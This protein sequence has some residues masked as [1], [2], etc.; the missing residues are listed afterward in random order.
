MTGTSV[1]KRASL[2]AVLLIF[3]CAGSFS[4]SSRNTGAVQ[5]DRAAESKG[6]YY[7]AVR[8]GL[9]TEVQ[10]ART[11]DNEA[12]VRA[13]IESAAHFMRNRS[14]VDLRG[15]IKTRLAEMEAATLEGATRR[16]TPD[17]L[18]EIIAITA[19]DRISTASDDEIG[20]AA[21]I[22]RGFDAPDL[23]ESFR[24]SREHI[25][26]RS[27][28]EGSL[29]PEE[30]VAQVKAIRDANP[31]LKWAV[32]KPMA[33][34]SASVEVNARLRTLSEAVPD[35]FSSPNL[36]LTPLQ[37]V[38]VTYSVVSEDNL[39][40]SATNL[41]KRMQSL[42]DAI[43]QKNGRPYADPSGH[44]A[45]GPNGYFVSTP[46]DL[47]FD[48]RTVNLLLD[49]IAERSRIPSSNSGPFSH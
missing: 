6:H 17:E 44:L 43:S 30:F 25:R 26:L 9:G 49:H 33:V 23:P 3:L 16:I 29:A 5:R 27:H 48:E 37:A 35:Q 28:L 45:Y 8:D 24:R 47:V 34:H 36:G 20:H 14:G 21:E 18:S 38:I 42:C 46:T 12:N 11:G 13:S 40:Y 10:L 2:F 19:L 32:L 22:M 41:R 31:I 4:F 15:Q 1:F 7:A 39:T